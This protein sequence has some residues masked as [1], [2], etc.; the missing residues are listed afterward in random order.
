MEWCPSIKDENLLITFPESYRK[1]ERNHGRVRTILNRHSE[2][3]GELSGDLPGGLVGN[4]TLGPGKS[5]LH[6]P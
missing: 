2:S 3:G 4:E 6:G 1:K 5:L